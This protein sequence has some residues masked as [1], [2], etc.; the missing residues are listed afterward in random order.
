M[1]EEDSRSSCTD[2]IILSELWY[3]SLVGIDNS[4]DTSKRKKS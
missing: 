3:G 1:A 2:F 4:F